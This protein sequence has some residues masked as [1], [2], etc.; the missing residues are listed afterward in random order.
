M[1]GLGT[2][3]SP[4]T[5]TPFPQELIRGVG[6]AG[7]AETALSWVNGGGGLDQ[8][9]ICALDTEAASGSQQWQS[10]FLQVLL[11]CSTHHLL[12]PIGFLLLAALASLLRPQAAPQQDSREAKARREE[13]QD[14]T[15]REVGWKLA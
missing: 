13:M 3:P 2:R 1:L 5:C 15:A 4:V 14:P 9:L 11:P 6:D 7:I 8:V 12:L 10:G